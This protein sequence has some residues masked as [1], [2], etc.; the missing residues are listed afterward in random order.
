MRKSVGKCQTYPKIKT[1]L[2]SLDLESFIA[3]ATRP[4]KKNQ[5]Q[6]SNLEQKGLQQKLLDW[7]WPPT[8]R[9]MA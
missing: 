5:S 2:P 7:K 1:V 6:K 8:S 4:P 3:N 9:N